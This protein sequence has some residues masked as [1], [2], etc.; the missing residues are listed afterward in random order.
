MSIHGDHTDNNIS[1]RSRSYLNESCD[2]GDFSHF[3]PD[4]YPG[5][6]PVTTTYNSDGEEDETMKR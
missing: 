4:L 1:N 5:S 2:L 3:E 6:D